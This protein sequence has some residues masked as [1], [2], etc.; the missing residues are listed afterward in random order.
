[1]AVFEKLSYGY[2]SDLRE[3]PDPDPTFEEKTLQTLRKNRYRPSRK[4]GSGSDLR[5]KTG[6][7]LEEKPVPTFYKKKPGSDP[8]KKPD[9][10]PA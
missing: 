9:T 6:T 7:D 10:D 3:K 5:G 8:R 1:M 2:G 4:T